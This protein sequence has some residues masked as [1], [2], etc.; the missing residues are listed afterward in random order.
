ML[1]WHIIF[2]NISTSAINSWHYITIERITALS[3]SH[4]HGI[5]CQSR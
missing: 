2:R 4:D 3:A 5:F 1:Y